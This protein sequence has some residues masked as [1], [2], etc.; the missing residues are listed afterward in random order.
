MFA[1]TPHRG[2]DKVKWGKTV[3]NL[4]Q[5]LYKD[6]STQML[7]AL[8]RGSD[9]I[10]MLQDS[11]KDIIGDFPIYTFLEELPLQKIGKVSYPSFGSPKHC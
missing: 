6:R 1:G 10:D 11:F 9:A 7:N 2:S 5:L 3:A 4:S 8:E